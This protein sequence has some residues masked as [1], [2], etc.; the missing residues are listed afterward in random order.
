MDLHCQD[1]CVRAFG[2]VR[3]CV[4]VSV[5]LSMCVSVR[6]VGGLHVHGVCVPGGCSSEGGLLGQDASVFPAP[7]LVVLKFTPRTFG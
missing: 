3:V 6:L 1:V 5:C 2:C 7:T 4:C